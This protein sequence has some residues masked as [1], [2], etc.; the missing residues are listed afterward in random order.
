MNK[1]YKPIGI[2]KLPFHDGDEQFTIIHTYE[3]SEEKK[4][5]LYA[6][7]SYRRNDGYFGPDNPVPEDVRD[8]GSV[9]DVILDD[10]N[11]TTDTYAMPGAT[12]VMYDATFWCGVVMVAETIARNV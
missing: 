2:T 5:F 6:V 9:E 7:Q 1:H 8:A 10:L 3:V 11:L 12:Y 4:N